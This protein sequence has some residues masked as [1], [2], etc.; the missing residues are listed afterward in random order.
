[1]KFSQYFE[2]KETQVFEENFN[3]FCQDL[4]LVDFEQVWK[5]ELLP[6][7]EQAEAFD[8][9][10]ELLEGLWDRVRNWAGGGQQQQQAPANNPS[11][12]PDAN[13]QMHQWLLNNDP[14]YARNHQR[15]QKLGQFQQHADQMSATIKNDFAN[16]MKMF[17]K[18]VN[19]DSMSQRNPYL[20]QI[21]NNFYKK[22]M[23]A[24]QPVMDRF[25]MN[26]VYGRPDH[27]EFN[28][29]MTGMQRSDTANLKQR[30]QTTQNRA[31]LASKK[32]GVPEDQLMA[33]RAM[34]N[35]DPINQN[36]QNPVATPAT[37]GV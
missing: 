23:A 25:K 21:A 19:D 24:V 26:A 33:R 32:T 6:I 37:P 5:E 22:I 31:K 35:P 15:Q 27:S 4:A 18:K 14:R 9:E 16:A 11:F 1:M 20:H 17:L 2:Q 3:L 28:N 10:A 36:W 30:L 12:T 29:K 13:P 8:N 34:G 7:L